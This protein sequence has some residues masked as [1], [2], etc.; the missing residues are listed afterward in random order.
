MSWEHIVI[1]DWTGKILFKGNY[2]DKEVDRVLKANRCSKCFG[3]GT[4]IIG[5]SFQGGSIPVD[6][7]ECGGSGYLGDFEVFWLNEKR[8]EID[9]VYEY[10]NY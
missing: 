3:D 7:N 8:G 9:N 1:K 4:V 6:C 5:R 2:L 10:I